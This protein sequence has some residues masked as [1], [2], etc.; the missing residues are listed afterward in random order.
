MLMLII[1]NSLKTIKAVLA[2]CLE[3]YHLIDNK[4]II[5]SIA[6]H[7]HGGEWSEWGSTVGLHQVHLFTL[8]IIMFGIIPQ[9][10]KLF[11]TLKPLFLT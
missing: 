7:H 6:N 4:S 9:T 2:S 8:N 3:H 11:L 1:F 10:Y 5:Q